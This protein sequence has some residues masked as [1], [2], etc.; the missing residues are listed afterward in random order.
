MCYQFMTSGQ[1]IEP[2]I[3]FFPLVDCYKHDL[4]EK[5][6]MLRGEKTNKTPFSESNL[7]KGN[8]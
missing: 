7:K 5:L 3:F 2:V 6:I 8:Q 1:E 4:R